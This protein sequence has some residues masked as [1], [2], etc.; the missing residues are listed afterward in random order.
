MAVAPPSPNPALRHEA[1]QLAAN[2][3][4]LLVEA[5]RVAATVAQGVHG[6]RRVGQGETFWQFRDYE[7]G[8][9]P[10]LIDWR[11]SAKSDRVFVREL[12]WEAAQSIWIWRDLSASTDWRSS[13]ALPTKR[14]RGDLLTLALA[15]LLIA[16]GEHVGLL[17]SATRPVTGRAGLTRLT[18]AVERDRGDGADLPPRLPL[19]R[20]AHLVRDAEKVAAA[21][22]SDS[23]VLLSVE[24]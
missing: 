8:D 16:A 13:R 18:L 4:P 10:Q 23:I 5:R 7:L 20:H 14:E 9:T 6:R 12:E 11:Q 3:P 1:E 19:P 17:G 15:V 2:L 21:R 22:T 24:N